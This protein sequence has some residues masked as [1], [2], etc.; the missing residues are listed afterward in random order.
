MKEFL[1][2]NESQNPFHLLFS[3]VKSVYEEI[4]LNRLKSLF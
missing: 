1:Q 2:I 3:S 4:D